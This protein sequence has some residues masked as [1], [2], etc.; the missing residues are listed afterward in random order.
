MKKLTKTTAISLVLAMAVAAFCA[1]LA[2]SAEGFATYTVTLTNNGDGTATITAAIPAGVASGKIVITPSEN[3]TLVEGSLR[4][5]VPNA[6]PYERYNRDGV[7]GQCVA[8]ASSSVIS[9][10]TLAFTADYTIKEGAKVSEADIICNLWNLG[11]SESERIATQDAGGVK[12]VYIPSKT[13]V[14][15]PEASEPEV[16]EPEVSEPEASEPEISEPEASEPEVSE[17]EV[18]EP[19]VSEPEASEPVEPKPSAK[20]GDAGLGV[21]AVIAVLSGAAAFIIKKRS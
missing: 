21:F 5:N 14:S 3:L 13:E 8:F 2:V 7:V 12:K 4:G 15:E 16:S 20:T 6:M 10:G 9:E 1:V 19:E 11:N 18:S 17:P